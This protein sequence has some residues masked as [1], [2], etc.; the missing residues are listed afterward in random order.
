MAMNDKTGLAK[1]GFMSELDAIFHD[2][3]IYILAA[4]LIYWSAVLDCSITVPVGFQTDLASVPRLPVIYS[5]WGDRAH[6]EAVL[7]DAL[8]RIDSVPS[9]SCPQA[10]RVFLE[11]ME[12]RGVSVWIR[13]P[14]Y[15]GVCAFGWCSYHRKKIKDEIK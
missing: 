9:V 14:M 8:Y 5:L 15:W 2:D 10:N 4:P 12:S 13:W 3:S 7:H 1:S 6:R 11:A